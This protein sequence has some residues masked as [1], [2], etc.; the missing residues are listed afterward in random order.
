MAEQADVGRLRPELWSPADGPAV[1]GASVAGCFAAFA[2]GE[3]GPGAAGDHAWVGAA[4]LVAG[5]PAPVA[6]TVV[7]TGRAGGP[8]VPGLLTMREGRMLHE[9]LEQLIDEVGRP[10]VVMVDATGRD[11]PRRCGMAVHLG[12]ALDVPTVGVTH[13]LLT[14]RDRAAPFL[15]RR[16]DW[17]PVRNPMTGGDASVEEEEVARWVCTRDGVRPL[18]AHAGWRTNAATA[19]DLAVGTATVARTPEP[20]R[21]AR[22]AARTARAAA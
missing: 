14:G 9:A 18:V 17:A 10:G 19:A 21:L 20:L 8:Y 15:P 4:L 22:E 12:W 11:H 3:A 1:A 16:G 7:T 6:I 5:G 13:R 2:P